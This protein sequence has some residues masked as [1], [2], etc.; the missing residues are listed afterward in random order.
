MRYAMVPLNAATPIGPANFQWTYPPEATRATKEGI[1]A[2]NRARRE[3]Q[4]DLNRDRDFRK[5][6]GISYADYE[7]MLVAQSGVCAVCSKPET[8]LQ[9]GAI[10]MLSVDHDHA[11]GAI[12]GL[13]CGNCNMAI[14]YACD[15]PN[16]LRDAADYL[17]SRGK[18]SK[19]ILKEYERQS[20]AYND[21]RMGYSDTRPV[22]PLSF[23][24]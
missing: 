3:R 13:L 14:G 21:P 11:T 16:I 8:K 1:E 12:R 19:D 22:V 2:L 10:R 23:G 20:Y 15:D 7:R 17:E 4:G 5:K 18:V 6:Y 24:A 9:N